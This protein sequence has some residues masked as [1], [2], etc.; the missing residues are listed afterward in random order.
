MEVKPEVLKQELD[1]WIKAFMK[2]LNGY[3]KLITI[4]EQNSLN[5]HYDFERLMDFKEELNKVKDDIVVIKVL[6]NAL[7]SERRGIQYDRFR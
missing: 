4:T 2:R 5:I 1:I 6:L 3:E 7:I